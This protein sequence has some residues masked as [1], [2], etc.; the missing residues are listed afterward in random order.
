MNE[1]KHGI[2]V[3]GYCRQCCREMT[4][5]KYLHKEANIIKAAHAMVTQ[6]SIHETM[7]PAVEAVSEDFPNVPEPLLTAIWIGIN[8]KERDLE[9]EALI[10]SCN[11]NHDTGGM[12]LE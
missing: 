5:A 8:A 1:C 12:N 2:P 6:H 4:T 9:M 7:L 11:D 3:F 10:T